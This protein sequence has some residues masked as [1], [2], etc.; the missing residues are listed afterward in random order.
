MMNRMLIA[1][2]WKQLHAV[3]NLCF[4][5]GMHKSETK[6]G[7]VVKNSKEKSHLLSKNGVALP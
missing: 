1:S 2:V 6:N 5:V 3:R 7:L 4:D